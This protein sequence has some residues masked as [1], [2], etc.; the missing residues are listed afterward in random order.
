ML[1]YNT[2]VIL[3]NMWYITN[4]II[5]NARYNVK[6]FFKSFLKNISVLGNTRF[7]LGRFEKALNKKRTRKGM[8]D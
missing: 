4:V 1:L 3:Y 8:K 7:N 5:N 2:Y 6:G